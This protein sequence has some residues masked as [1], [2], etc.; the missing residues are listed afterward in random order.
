MNE[1]QLILVDENDKFLG[2]HAPKNR[3]HNGQGLHHRGFTVMVLNNRKEVL[4]QK[5]KHK[6]WDG[7]WDL[8]NSH[9]LHLGNKNETYNQAVRRCL[10]REWGVEFPVKKIFGFNYFAKYEGKLCENEY[11]AFLIGKYND[12]V[13]PNPEVIY[14]YKWMPLE[15]LLKDI[16]KSPKIY[17]PWTVKA[18]QEFEKRRIK[19][20]F[21]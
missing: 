4:L 16:K 20:R 12:E 7:F 17:T 2:K 9:P 5:R 11:C 18:L 6:I 21:N 3:C 19:L 15:D 14:T 1:Q 13:F 10:K 8:T